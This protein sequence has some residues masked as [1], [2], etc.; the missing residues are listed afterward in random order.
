[1]HT[2]RKNSIHLYISLLCLED[3]RAMSAV[4][5]LRVHQTLLDGKKD[6]DVENARNMHARSMGRIALFHYASALPPGYGQTYYKHT[7][8]LCQIYQ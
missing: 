6:D 3:R 5:F 2:V 8:Q 1:M 7:G 4:S